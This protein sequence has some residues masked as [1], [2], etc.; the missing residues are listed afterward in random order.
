MKRVVS[1]FG[2]RKLLETV[3]RLETRG[4][5][6]NCWAVCYKIDKRKATKVDTKGERKEE[7]KEQIRGYLF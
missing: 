7:Q 4:K 1:I 6:T 5:I 3:T 2:T